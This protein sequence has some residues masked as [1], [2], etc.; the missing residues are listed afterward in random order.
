MLNI[1]PSGSPIGAIATGIDLSKPLDKGAFA[2]L[3]NAFNTHQVL[4]IRDQSLSAPQYIAFAKRF[5]VVTELFLNH[6][7]H[8]DHPEI[9]R[10]SNIQE[11]GVAQGHAD[12]GRVWHSDMSYLADPPRATLLYALEVP[13]EN[14]VA[15]GDTEFASATTAYEALAP[16]V[17]K[18][19][20]DLSA[21]HDVFGRRGRTGISVQDQ[22]LR[23]S[24]PNVI[25]PVVRV[26]PITGRKSIYVNEGE[27]IGV[28]GM[29]KDDALSLISDLAQSI[30][31]DGARYKHS[32][33]VGD[34]LIWDNCAVQH[35]ATFDYTWPQHRRSMQRITVG[36][37]T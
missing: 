33:R 25:H 13:T 3:D 22:E 17:Q 12:A 36:T 23:Q 21:I 16:N 35:I 15:L 1:S 7:A 14:G 37:Q 34:I 24:Q 11:N 9:A 30:P 20:D 6:Y 8:P 32:W 29:A 2:A 27:C 10:I 5:G 4:C 26:H 19:I 28:E 31:N 18:Q